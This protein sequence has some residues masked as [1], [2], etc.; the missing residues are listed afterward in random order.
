VKD[1]SGLFRVVAHVDTNITATSC[2][3]CTGHDHELNDLNAT[4]ILLLVQRDVI[5]TQLPDI[6]REGSLHR[7]FNSKV[8][9]EFL[10]GV[11]HDINSL[12][13]FMKRGF[14]FGNVIVVRPEDVQCIPRGAE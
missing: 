8:V 6:Y 10:G 13:V 9:S 5:G 1:Q 11:G 12:D 4:F 14:D 2:G 3:T 7:I